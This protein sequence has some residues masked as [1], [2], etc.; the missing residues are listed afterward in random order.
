MITMQARILIFIALLLLLVVIIYMVRQRSLELKYVLVWLA[1]D[2]VMLIM[3]AFPAL[4]DW[5]AEA[6][7]IYSVTNMVFFLAFM[8]SLCVC[9]SLTVAL[10]RLSGAIRRMAQMVSMLPEDVRQD[11]MEQLEKA[12]DGH[13]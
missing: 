10:S 4:L 9:F 5:L 2:L 13:K 12:E 8:F 6:L 7:G 3:I 1:G 11:I